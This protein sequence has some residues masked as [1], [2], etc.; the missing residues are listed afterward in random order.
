MSPR[1]PR[2]EESLR[3]TG[4]AVWGFHM[5]VLAGGGALL[6]AAPAESS[7][8]SWGSAT[9]LANALFTVM[10]YSF[11]CVGMVI[12]HRKPRNRMGWLL[13]LGVGAAISVPSLF[14]YYATVTITFFPDARVGGAVAAG[15]VE[16]S[17]IWLIGSVGVFVIL[18]FPD[19]RLPSPR[20]RWLPVVA[21]TTMVVVAGGITLG[22]PT[23]TEG[24]VPGMRNPL[25]LPSL[26]RSLFEVFIY[27]LPLLPASI[28][29]A[30]VALGVRF[31][32]SQG[33]EREQLKWLAE[34]GIL[35]A[36]F[37]LAAMLAQFLKP[38]PFTD[39]PD[40][41]WLVVLQNLALA[42][43]GLIP[44]ALA[45]ALLRHRLYD[46]DRILNR[47]A[48]YAVLTAALVGTYLVTVLLFRLVLDPLIGSSDL[49]VAASTLA[50][51]A[52]FRPVRSRVQRAVDRRFDRRKYDGVRSVEAFAGRLRQEVDLDAVSNDLRAV[53]RDTV[54]P[55]HVSLWLRS[56]P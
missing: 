12:V 4:W 44:V 25:Y 23:L 42:S 56:A 32:R 55:D 43:F 48:V 9:A 10:V 39:A 37:Y 54:Q 51:A 27:V 33:I 14:D 36:T 49:A 45:I 15:V 5:V 38:A 53:V 7:A 11:P 16:S 20:W 34:A 8:S 41:G 40:P 50:V 52:L 29:A 21:L 22:S 2:S 35:V 30:A 28:V 1:R 3:R 26:G 6:V 18:L 31:R 13:L 19:G 17:W 46:I 47:T 24:P